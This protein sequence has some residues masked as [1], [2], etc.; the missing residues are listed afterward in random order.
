VVLIP[1]GRRSGSREVL[2]ARRPRLV[3]RVCSVGPRAAHGQLR[4][5]HRIRRWRRRQRWRCIAVTLTVSSLDLVE[6][7]GGRRV[8][9][10]SIVGEV[11]RAVACWCVHGTAE[12]RRGECAVLWCGC[13]IGE[14]ALSRV[15]SISQFV[16]TRNE[17][18]AER[19]KALPSDGSLVKRREFKSHR[20]H[21]CTEIG[22]LKEHH[23][24]CIH[25][26][27][28]VY[29]CDMVPVLRGLLTLLATQIAPD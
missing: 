3:R 1:R 29:C 12:K 17:C 15:E 4:P 20:T 19:S 25:V 24:F 5:D 11:L 8:R 23:R 27:V 14:R 13:V 16:S 7:G 21:F 10:L 22:Q 18:V 26:C 2:R 6:R 9:C 28:A